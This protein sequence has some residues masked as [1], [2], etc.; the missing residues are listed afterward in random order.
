MLSMCKNTEMVKS[1]GKWTEP[2]K[3]LSEKSPITK[4]KHYVFSLLVRTFSQFETSLNHPGG[5]KLS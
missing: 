3:L 4:D 5:G 1:T 2:G